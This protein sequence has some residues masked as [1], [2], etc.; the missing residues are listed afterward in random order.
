M[1]K[2]LGLAF[3][4]LGLTLISVESFAAETKLTG[5]EIKSTHS[6]R[7]FRF[8]ASTGS[9]GE[10][11]YKPDGTMEGKKDGGASDSGKWWVKDNKICRQWDKW[12][13]GN[14]GCFHIFRIGDKRYKG[15]RTDGGRTKIIW[16][17]YSYTS[18]L[19]K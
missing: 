6:G 17:N 2:R 14:W 5:N 1:M 8:K 3:A 11:S 16:R 10:I 18:W 9:T 13:R 4:I 19:I 7:T 12:R 15:V